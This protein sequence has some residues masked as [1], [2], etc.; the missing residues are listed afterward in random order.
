MHQLRIREGEDPCLHF[1][2]LLPLQLGRA[3]LP[4]ARL[5]FEVVDSVQKYLSFALWDFVDGSE[6]Q[7]V[8][9]FAIVSY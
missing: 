7:I 5:T 6:G 8:W 3:G 2:V 9:I 1:L 4:F